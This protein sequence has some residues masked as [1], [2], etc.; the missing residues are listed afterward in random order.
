MEERSQYLEI[1]PGLP[2]KS[3]CVCPKVLHFSEVLKRKE[4]KKNW[5]DDSK[6]HFHMKMPL[7]K[8]YR[9]EPTLIG[10]KLI[11][12][13]GRIKSGCISFPRLHN[14]RANDEHRVLLV[15]QFVVQLS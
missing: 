14:F 15:V 1:M 11:E 8:N 7:R 13:P 9:F 3:V 2:N 5:L 6:G 12:H 10:Q 4:N